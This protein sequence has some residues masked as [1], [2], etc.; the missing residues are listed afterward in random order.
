MRQAL[1]H[2]PASTIY[3]RLATV[4]LCLAWQINK[5]VLSDQGKMMDAPTFN[6]TR[7]VRFALRFIVFCFSIIM[8]TL[9][10]VIKP[11]HAEGF[12][13][14]V[15]SHYW[16]SGVTYPSAAAYCAAAYAYYP[17]S[18]DWVGVFWSGAEWCGLENGNSDLYPINKNNCPDHSAP[19]DSS[20]RYNNACA[21][22]YP[23]VPDSAGTSCIQEQY[24]IALSGLGVDVMPTKTL[25]TA[26]AKV[27]TSDGKSKSGAHVD[28]TLTVVPEVAGQLPVTYTGS[29]STYAGSTG[30]DG[31]LTFEFRAP[32]AGGTH[33]ITATCTNCT[34]Q[35]TGTIKV[36]GCT[37]SDLTDVKKLS[38]L[39]GET[40]EQT[41]L[42]L[43][44][45]NGMNGYS[46]LSPATQVA[47]Q[48]LAGR[49]N[50][51]VGSP[52][53]SGYK[54]TSTIRTYAYQK[55]LWE[56]WDKFKELKGKVAND[57]SIQQSCQ[58][59]I[60]KVEGEMG[61]R[62]TQN[63]KID[64]CTLGRAH[65]VRYEP[66]TDD[67]KHVAKIAFDIPLPTVEAF[68]R[69]LRRPPPS[70]VQQEA[71]TCGL[72]WGGTFSSPDRIHFL[73]R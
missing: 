72:N 15:P 37:V 52:S 48:C 23:Y 36:P 6:A 41:Q 35:E 19:T 14:R 24:T 30:S 58:T 40:P 67:P 43:D 73:L 27:T 1:A 65:C 5:S 28:L 49:V 44:L 56:V 11:A 9:M 66:A 4:R 34:N 32:S 22:D 55:H 31:R 17:A 7:F 21:C 8:I 60:T 3:W 13:L 64:D 68:E 61:L 63:P 51:V 53:T 38:E 25:T 2:N 54:V 71:N 45:D 29:L 39:E 33:T 26:Y 69:R 62:L 57:P 20:P 50:T 16:Y 59:L 47:E 18:K 70:T 10:P 46:L 42:T 12:V